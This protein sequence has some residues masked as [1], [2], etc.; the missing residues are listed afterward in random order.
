MG[1]PL[2]NWR[3][4]RRSMASIQSRT[5]KCQT[6]QQAL[7]QMMET[8]WNV[9]SISSVLI[10][11]GS[12]LALLIAVVKEARKLSAQKRMDAMLEEQAKSARAA[13]DEIAQHRAE[14]ALAERAAKRR[15]PSQGYKP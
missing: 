11:S 9:I 8:L 7:G 15:H 13:G 6:H 10:V 4:N 12:L 14:R 1:L 5:A 2:G 3:T